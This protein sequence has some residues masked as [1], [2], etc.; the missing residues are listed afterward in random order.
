MF[1]K[2]QEKTGKYRRQPSHAFPKRRKRN[3]A[4]RPRLYAFAGKG[5][6]K[7]EAVL[8]S[9]SHSHPAR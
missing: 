5:R 6:A 8:K 4:G 7:A 1:A 9:S 2:K 3:P